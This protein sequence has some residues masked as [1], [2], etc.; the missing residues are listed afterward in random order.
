MIRY[1]AVAS[2]AA[3]LIRNHSIQLDQDAIHDLRL[4][5]VSAIIFAV[6]LATAIQL[7]SLGLTRIYDQPETYDWW[8]IGASYLIALFLQDSYF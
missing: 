4:S 6:A 1:L 2:L 7:H 5:F 3:C 8:Y